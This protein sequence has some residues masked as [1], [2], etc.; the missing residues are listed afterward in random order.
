M[1]WEREWKCRF[2]LFLLDPRFR[3]APPLQSVALSEGL[4]RKAIGDV[5]PGTR[6]SPECESPLVLEARGLGTLLTWGLLKNTLLGNAASQN[7]PSGAPRTVLRGPDTAIMAFST[8]PLTLDS[9]CL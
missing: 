4:N 8:A 5:P 2:V 1:T 6:K 3:F 9:G 7:G